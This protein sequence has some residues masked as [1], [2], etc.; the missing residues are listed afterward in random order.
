M[1][2]PNMCGIHPFSPFDC[3]P[4]DKTARWRVSDGHRFS[5]GRIY[6]YTIQLRFINN[7]YRKINSGGKHAY[8]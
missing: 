5:Q 1:M 8:Q 3:M 4:N 7:T 6:R 2:D